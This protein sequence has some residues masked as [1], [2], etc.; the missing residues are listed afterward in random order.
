M[1]YYRN[2]RDY[3]THK[4]G[5]TLDNTGAYNRITDY[6]DMELGTQDYDQA[7]KELAVFIEQLVM[8]TYWSAIDAMPRGL[9]RD[10]ISEVC[11]FGQ[12]NFYAIAEGYLEDYEPMTDDA[13]ELEEMA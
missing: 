6:I 2:A 8:Q 3:Y 4:V 9:A 7:V 1:S 12:T 13:I 10:L 11:T 5:M